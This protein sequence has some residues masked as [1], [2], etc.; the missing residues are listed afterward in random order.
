MNQ[1]GSFY[2]CIL[3]LGDQI[4]LP[5]LGDAAYKQMLRG[6]GESSA[7]LAL[8][9]VAT[10][11]VLA[12][13]DAVGELRALEDDDLDGVMVSL[14]A[15]HPE[16]QPIH[17]VEDEPPFPLPAPV[18]D[19]M[20]ANSS[21]SDA[22]VLVSM[23]AGVGPLFNPGSVEFIHG[24]MIEG[25][26]IEVDM[27]MDAGESYIRWVVTCPLQSCVHRSRN[28]CKKKRN[29]VL[30]HMQKHG[31]SEIYAYLGCWLK[32]RHDFSSQPLHVRYTPT[33]K[34]MADYCHDK[35]WL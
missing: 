30:K 32:A 33:S 6:A 19:G 31:V 2:E 13:G 15:V 11:E 1:P 3:Q 22:E 12:I 34:E 14:N 4:V 35:G 16:P 29:I 8:R 18:A 17:D 10:D 27:H 28:P 25:V 7:M 24:E 23:G 26:P 21:D 20:P 5:Q 9:D